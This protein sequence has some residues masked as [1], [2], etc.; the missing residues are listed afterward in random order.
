MTITTR[1]KELIKHQI[2]NALSKEKEIQKIVLFGSFVNSD[3]PNDVDIA[4]FQNSNE[5]Y[6]PLALKYRKL[7]RPVSKII[8]VDIFPL[9]NNAK[10]FFLDEIETGETIYERWD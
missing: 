1:Q 7:I 5:K 6:L 10:G 8:P 9:K 2:I 3:N 4:V